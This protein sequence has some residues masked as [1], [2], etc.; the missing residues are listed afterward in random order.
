MKTKLLYILSSSETDIFLESA[1]ISIYSVKF[2]MPDINII[3]LVDDITNNNFVGNRN[4]LL[5]FISEKIVINFDKDI[6]FKTRSRLLK[7]NMRNHISGDFLYIDCDTL[8]ASPLNDIDNCKFDI[9][10]VLD[11]HSELQKHP[12]YEI[13]AKQSSVFNY[14][15][16]KVENYFS[17]GV[18]YVKDSEKAHNFFD[19]WHKNYKLGLKFDICQDEPSLAKTNFDF[20]NII[21]KLPGEWNCQ[22]RLGALYLKDL[23]I[24]H[25]WSKRNMPISFLGSKDFLFKLKNE[26]F[27]KYQHFIIDYHNT[28]YEP[29]GIVTNEDLYFN[30]SPLYEEV[31][32]RFLEEN[33]ISYF[34]NGLTFLEKVDNKA[35][36]SRLGKFFMLVNKLIF[37]LE[38]LMISKFFKLKAKS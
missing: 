36:Q 2:R 3:L 6:D 22:I 25:F 18:M 33:G 26:G 20:G 28:F 32:K 38:Y 37:R 21:H 17:G 10:A 19:S 15:F 16:K 9:A 31:R 12:V 14:P 11:G 13:F 7:T 24:L 8:I 23:K 34:Q 35:T 27:I 4:E 5:N 30:F 29:L 1:L